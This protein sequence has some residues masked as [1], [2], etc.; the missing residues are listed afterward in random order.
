MRNDRVPD[1]A[2]PRAG[3][4]IQDAGATGS[5]D[6]AAA[7]SIEC[8]ASARALEA[9][10]DSGGP[11][12]LRLALSAVSVGVERRDDC[13]TGDGYPVASDG[14]PT[15]LALEVAQSGRSAEDTRGDPPPDPRDEPG[16][17]A[18]G[19]APYPRRTAQ[20]RH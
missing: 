6:R 15:V 7:T 8:A 11:T 16:Q 13:P 10:A 9:E 18:V 14:V 5:R 17:P 12:A 1:P 3:L 20:A 2:L 19:Y 4:A